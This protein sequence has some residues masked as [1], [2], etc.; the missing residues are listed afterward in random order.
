MTTNLTLI[1]ILLSLAKIIWRMMQTEIKISPEEKYELISRNLQEVLG[2]EKIKEI[3][4]ERD[5]KLY[6]GTATTGKPHI[7]YFV[8]MSKIA[9]F[10]RAGAEVVILFADLHAYLDNM[11][12]PWNLLELRVQYYEHSIKAMLQSIGVPLNKLKF[13]KG[14]DYELSREYT[15]DVYRLTSVVTEHDAKKAGAEVVK[16]VENALLSGLL[17]PGLQALD[18]EYLKVDAQFGGVDQR[19]I[20]TFAE[21]YLPQLGYQKRAHLMNP[22]V[23]GLTGTK[24]SSSEEDSKIDLLDSPANVKK[25]LKK[26]FCEPGNIENNGILSF[27]KHVLFPLFKPDETFV[28]PRKAEYGGDSFYGRFED[29]EQAFAKEEVHPGDLKAAVEIYI[30]RLLE[31]IR[32]EFEK[33]ELKKLAQ[34]A[35]PSPS[36]ISEESRIWNQQ[37]RINGKIEIDGKRYSALE[38]EEGKEESTKVAKNLKKTGKRIGKETLQLL[39]NEKTYSVRKLMKVKKK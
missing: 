14:T 12:A 31:P 37:A 22:M 13:V 3:L 27:T 36:K 4:K 16:Q 28:V 25:K 29:L 17:Y 7:A 32:K 18:E 5:L 24:M 23:P 11:K 8:P 26:A 15:L 38:L 20:F 39:K 35:Y 34:S 10:L 19:K 9:D 30:N 1:T 21:K 33:P 6:W 2:E